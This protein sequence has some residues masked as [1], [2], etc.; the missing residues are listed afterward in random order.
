MD[1]RRPHVQF[2]EFCPESLLL[3]GPPAILGLVVFV[4]IV[5]VIAVIAVA[6]VVA[7]IHVGNVGIVS[8]R[9][10][11]RA[12]HEGRRAAPKVTN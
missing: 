6:I 7:T 3:Y 8:T 5:V 1:H 4:V 12:R 9:K 11:I 2:C 10:P